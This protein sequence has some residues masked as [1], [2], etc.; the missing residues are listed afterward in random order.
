M[1][2]VHSGATRNF[3]DFETFPEDRLKRDFEEFGEID[4][5]IFLRETY[6][7]VFFLLFSL[8]ADRC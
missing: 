1:L 2:A 3:E 6:I 4:L 8:W 7:F 5:V